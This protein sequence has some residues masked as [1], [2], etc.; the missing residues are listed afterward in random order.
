MYSLMIPH[1]AWAA[2][3]GVISIA[4][5]SPIAKGARVI[6]VTS[7]IDETVKLYA[8]TTHQE[9]TRVI[10][11]A[12]HAIIDGKAICTDEYQPSHRIPLLHRRLSHSRSTQPIPSTPGPSQ[13]PTMPIGGDFSSSSS[14]NSG[15]QIPDVVSPQRR[16][17]LEA[18]PSNL[19]DGTPSLLP[20]YTN[21][22]VVTT[23]QVTIPK[24]TTPTHNTEPIIVSHRIRW[25]IMIVN[26][27][28]H[29]SELRCSL[30]LH[31]L[32]HQL[33][34]ETRS[35]TAAT[36]RL[37]LG[38][39]AAPSEQAEEDTQLPS[40]PSH[41]RDRV[42]D[43]YSHSPDYPRTP[44]SDVHP[45]S[46]T[47]SLNGLTSTPPGTPGVSGN[48]SLEWVTSELLRQQ[49]ASSSAQQA[50]IPITP[51]DSRRP[52]RP[53]SRSGSRFS[54]RFPSRAPS[55]ERVVQM[56]DAASPSTS[57][58]SMHETYVHSSST[59]SRNLNNLS[60][61][62][63]RPLTTLSHPFSLSSR[64][65]SYST[66]PSHNAAHHAQTSSDFNNPRR[67]THYGIDSSPEAS[68]PLTLAHHPRSFTEVP[69]YEVASRGFAGGGIPPLTSLRGLPSYEQA[70]QVGA[71]TSRS[72]SAGDTNLTEDGAQ[73]DLFMA[74]SADP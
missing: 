49:A 37:L 59:A 74:D 22:D 18:G 36:H 70:S 73:E 15:T 58:N 68:S 16:N 24:N 13:S 41:V 44:S 12:K 61:T 46:F 55:P 30:P 4:K 32:D 7:T 42:P 43:V 56:G 50:R 26:F 5:F 71:G 39:P 47:P 28:G 69:D 27:D 48:M 19:V 65:P 53:N 29:T 1:R 60:H 6:S 25:S 8:R 35:L 34:Q 10:T 67:S 72:G 64:T 33:L 11:T 40:Y 9:T 31:I 66:L 51:P 23:I 14:S 17:S 52:S 62:P 57:P 45:S 2:G 63:M 21:E 54:S 3:D 38:G 20:V